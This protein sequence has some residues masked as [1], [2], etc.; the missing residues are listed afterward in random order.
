MKK[1]KKS[2]LNCFAKSCAW[3]AHQMLNGTCIAEEVMGDISRAIFSGDETLLLEVSKIYAKH[4][5]DEMGFDVET[6]E[7][8]DFQ[9]LIKLI[10][11][12]CED[13]D[14]FASQ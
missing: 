3:G 9:S 1:Y 5:E 4:A 7:V 11:Q 14:W 12:C 2:E 8:Q 13:N 6:G 10:V